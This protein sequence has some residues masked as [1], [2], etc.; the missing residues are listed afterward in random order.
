MVISG[1]SGLGI[2]DI[3]NVC[4]LPNAFV[5]LSSYAKKW[6]QKWSF[7]TRVEYI[8]NGVD[9]QKFAPKG[10]AVYPIIKRPIVLFVGVLEAGKRPLCTVEA[11]SKMKK[12]ANLFLVGWEYINVR[13]FAEKILGQFNERFSVKSFR[14]G[15]MPKVYRVADVFTIPSESYYA[16]EIVLLEAMA[17]GLPVVTNDDPIRREIVGNA[18]IFVDPENTDEYAKA[19]DTALAKNWGDLPRRQAEKFS[20]DKV[21]EQYDSLFK[22]LTR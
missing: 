17:S 6:A 18:G 21:A 3:W 2:D 5:A 1:Q 4:C 9:T 16:F 7:I 15:A 10:D 22:S 14:H 12:K 11:V 13:T 20:W 19:L 8:P